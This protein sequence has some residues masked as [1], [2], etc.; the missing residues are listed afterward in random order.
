MSS[1]IFLCMFSASWYVCDT[2][3]LYSKTVTDREGIQ[4]LQQDDELFAPR[5]YIKLIP[6][7]ERLE[8]E[9]AR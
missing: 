5:Q 6:K 4:S 1:A 3:D 7:K 8:G 9:E 2:N